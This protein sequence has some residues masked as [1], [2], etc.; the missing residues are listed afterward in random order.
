MVGVL[1]AQE[2]GRVPETIPATD[3]DCVR[4]GAGG[5]HDEALS[6]LGG[7]GGLPADRRKESVSDEHGAA[8]HN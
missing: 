8:F 2:A 4:A 7:Q 5:M 3:R 6:A 1:S